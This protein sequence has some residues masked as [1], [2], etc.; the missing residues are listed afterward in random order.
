MEL[1]VEKAVGIVKEIAARKHALHLAMV[2][3]KYFHSNAK[4]N[5]KKFNGKSRAV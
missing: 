1:T 2:C 5:A 3:A 4:F